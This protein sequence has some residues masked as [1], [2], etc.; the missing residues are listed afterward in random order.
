MSKMDQEI[1][2]KWLKAL[3]SSEY[4]QG[5]GAMKR[6]DCPFEDLGSPDMKS[7]LSYC[8]LGVLSE[9]C[10]I[11]NTPPMDKGYAD[12]VGNYHFQYPGDN[13][14]FGGRPPAEWI[15]SIGIPRDTIQIL[16]DKN[17]GL[18]PFTEIADWI[19][20]NL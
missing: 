4:K 2:Q 14:D 9:V 7:T 1:K 3:R 15:K 5:T 10:N 18:E 16:I 19:E 11:K 13:T 6:L 12:L 8:C 17:D 20:E